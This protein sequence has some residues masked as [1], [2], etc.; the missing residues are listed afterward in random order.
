MFSSNYGSILHRTTI[1]EAS[2]G[3]SKNCEAVI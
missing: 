1:E 2:R 3:L